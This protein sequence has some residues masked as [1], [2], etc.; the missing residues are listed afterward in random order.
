MAAGALGWMGKEIK[1]WY[2]RVPSYDLEKYIIV[3]IPPF[4]STNEKGEKKAVYL[5]IPHDD[6]NRI[7]AASTWAIFTAHRPHSLAHA[8]S[9]VAGEFPGVTPV[10]KLPST[11]LQ[12]AA[13]RNPYD[14]FR[15]R[16]VVPRTQWDAGG[17]DRWKEVGRHTLGEFGIVSQILGH[18][19]YGSPEEGESAPGEEMIR[20][21]P[22]LSSLIKITDRGLNESRYWELD[23]EARDRARLRMDLS[24]AVRRATSERNT[25]NRF[26]VERLTPE[27]QDRRD[28]L[29]NWYRNYYLPLTAEM[30]RRREEKDDA[31]YKASKEA[32][33]KSIANIGEG[34]QAGRGRSRPARRSRRRR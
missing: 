18:W 19:T 14:S 27:E 29:N 33:N 2:D 17:W 10:L 6:V 31:A 34:G 12:A 15:G 9:I 30:T 5:R 26:G 32:L 20:S 1:E 11:I 4:Y 3:P 28:D 25:K 24:K 16:D 7:L 8:A 22:G 23:W 21:V 13:N